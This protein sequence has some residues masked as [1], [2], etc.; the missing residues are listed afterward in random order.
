[1]F[2]RGLSAASHEAAISAA[3]SSVVK[4]STADTSVGDDENWFSEMVLQLLG[5]EKP[6]TALD[7][8]TELQFGE[9]NC[10]RYA[11]GDVKPPAYFLR[12][13]LRSEHG[14]PF[15][16]AVMDGC[17]A[18]WWLDLQRERRVG[19]AAILEITKRT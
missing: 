15:F 12:A 9:R 19:A 14:A 10:Q 16:N 11:S 13:L 8:V 3:A 17:T 18:R 7:C 1:M 6:G 5:P 2:M 4:T